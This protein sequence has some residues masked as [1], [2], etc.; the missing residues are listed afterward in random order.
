MWDARAFFAKVYFY[1]KY[2]GRNSYVLDY[3]VFLG[4]K[5]SPKGTSGTQVYIVY[6]YNFKLQ[7]HDGSIPI[8]T[9]T[10]Y[11]SIYT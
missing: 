4:W 1:N 6:S 5:L 3:T 10:I 7:Y 8:T 9:F 2:A 11:Y